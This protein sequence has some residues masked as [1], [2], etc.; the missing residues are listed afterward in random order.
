MKGHFSYVDSLLNEYIYSVWV[1]LIAENCSR[2]YQGDKMGCTSQRVNYRVEII[3]S[4]MHGILPL[5]RD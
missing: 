1:T 5:K 4:F 3:E 2:Q